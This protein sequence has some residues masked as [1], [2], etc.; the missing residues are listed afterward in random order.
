MW[1]LSLNASG[2]VF[3]ALI[4]LALW[5]YQLIAKRRYEIAEQLV[6][7]VTRAVGALRWARSRGG[8]RTEGATRPRGPNESLEDTQ[9]LNALYRPIERLASDDDVFTELWRSQVL[10]EMHFGVEAGKPF[11]ALFDTRDEIIMA[12]RLQLD[13]DRTLSEE[14]RVKTDRT[15]Y[16]GNRGDD[17]EIGPRIDAAFDEIKQLA[18]SHLRPQWLT[19]LLPFLRHEHVTWCADKAPQWLNRASGRI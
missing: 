10:A 9:R 15:I 16:G 18:E 12:A 5:R 6:Q 2:A 1:T 13:A 7:V 19:L 17:D 11:Q 14:Q 3:A 4:A 8:Y